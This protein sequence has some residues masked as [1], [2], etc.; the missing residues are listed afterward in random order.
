MTQAI[1]PR[2][3]PHP[4]RTRSVR[5]DSGSV[6]TRLLETILDGLLNVRATNG[7]NQRFARAAVRFEFRVP[8]VFGAV[9]DC[10]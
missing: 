5:R 3:Q 2:R 1:H 7:A 8:F 4:L 9:G 6:Q 10:P